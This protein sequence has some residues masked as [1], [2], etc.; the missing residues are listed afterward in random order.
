MGVVGREPFEL[1]VVFHFIVRILSGRLPVRIYGR[2]SVNF[3]AKNVYVEMSVL[4]NPNADG[5]DGFHLVKR[6]VFTSLIDMCPAECHFPFPPERNFPIF[7]SAD[8]EHAHKKKDI[9]DW[10]E[11]ERRPGWH[12]IDGFQVR[13]H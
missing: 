7:P 3:A 1:H 2:I 10:L 13:S 9:S 5:I 12:Y 6:Y 11:C 8:D 4:Y